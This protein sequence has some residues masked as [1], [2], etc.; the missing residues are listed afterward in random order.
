MDRFSRRLPSRFADKGYIGPLFTQCCTHGSAKEKPRTCRQ[1]LA[2]FRAEGMGFEPTT[3]CGAPDFESGR[4]PIRLP[5][6]HFP[7]IEPKTASG[8]S[9]RRRVPFDPHQASLLV[10]AGRR[11]AVDNCAIMTT[12]SDPL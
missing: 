5:S 10:L 7:K 1:G 12:P 8:K 2:A 3:P 6:R 11:R 4:W 9:A